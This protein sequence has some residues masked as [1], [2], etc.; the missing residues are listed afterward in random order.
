MAE[1]N[2]IEKRLAALRKMLGEK[3]LDGALFTSYENR[4]YYSGFSGSAG[5]LIVGPERAILITDKRY[6]EQAEKQ[7]AQNPA[8]I[9]VYEHG[10]GR[11]KRAAS[12]VCAL[13]LS[14]IAFEDSTPLSEYLAITKE[15]P[16]VQ[17]QA[18]GECFLE[19]RMIKDAGEIELIRQAEACGDRAFAKLIPRLKAGMSEK[20]LADELHY[21][22]SKEGAQTPSFGTIV[23]A[24]AH[25][26]MAHWSPSDYKIKNG[27]LV[28]VDFGVIIGGYCSDMTRTLIFGDPGKD[29]MR[30]FNLVR[31]SME[32]AFRAIRPGVLA[33]EVEEAH[34]EV[35]RRA[36]VEEYALKGLG[37]GVG[38]EI[39][40]CPRVVIGNETVLQPDMVF[41]VEPGL[42]FPD[43]HGVRHED[44]VLVTA[45]GYENLTGTPL[46]IRI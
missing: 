5:Y 25:G 31:E 46:E 10:Q 14:H 44:L 22:A 16:E 32:A 4:R 8:G 26:A 11:Q 39:H 41:T 29:E 12:E 45:D 7:T 33:K 18:E 43:K 6:T 34:R 17:V 1:R 37:H 38:L 27:E 35:F 36:G 42:Y 3:G 20:D 2:V 28:V 15:M 30:T 23:A 40:E 13:G 21:L 9:T 24:G 19:Q